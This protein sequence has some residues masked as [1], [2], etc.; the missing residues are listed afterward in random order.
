M[1]AARSVG[2]LDGQRGVLGVLPALDTTFKLGE[3]MFVSIRAHAHERRVKYDNCTWFLG[4]TL[5][6]DKPVDKPVRECANCRKN[7]QPTSARRMLCRL[8]YRV[9]L[10][11]RR[12]T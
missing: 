2:A 4:R 8:C 9:G 7:F 5:P 1:R 12:N 10:P 3:K 11:P 6:L